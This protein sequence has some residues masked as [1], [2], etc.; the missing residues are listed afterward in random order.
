MAFGIHTP[1]LQ[2]SYSLPELAGQSR[3]DRD[4]AFHRIEKE[5]AIASKY[6][7]DYLLFHFPFPPIFAREKNNEYWTGYPT[8]YPYLKSEEVNPELFWEN[9]VSV[10]ERLCEIQREIGQKFVLEYD[11]FG[12]FEDIFV[13]LFAKFPELQLVIDT[14]RIDMHK[15]TFLNFDPYKW[16][17]RIADYVYLA[18]YSNISYNHP[19]KRHLP[20]LK[21]QCEEEEFG[22]S[23]QYLKYLAQRNDQFHVTFEHNPALVSLEELHLCYREVY[24]MLHLGKAQDN[25]IVKRG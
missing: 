3:T 14:Q 9:S 16:L 15:R 12:D 2:E 23:Y 17:A 21:E 22:D 19:F 6:G 25:G 24:E 13:A 20:V 18:H 5:A 1:V 8:D 4:A 7:A 10:F 11:F